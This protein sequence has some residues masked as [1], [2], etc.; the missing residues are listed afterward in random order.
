MIW[1]LG[2]TYKPILVLEGGGEYFYGVEKISCFVL[3]TLIIFAFFGN[4]LVWVA[5]LTVKRLQ[6]VTNFYIVSLATADLLVASFAMTTWLL[7]M[8]FG[9]KIL[10]NGSTIKSIYTL[11]DIACGTA[12]ILN[13]T[14]LGTIL[15]SWLY[16][17]L[18]AATKLFVPSKAYA[19]FVAL[20]SF[21]IPTSLMV[22]TYSCIFSVARRHVRVINVISGNRPQRRFSYVTE[23]KAAKVIGV[24]V[25]AF[26]V[27]WA[28]FLLTNLVINYCISCARSFPV[29]AVYVLKLLQYTSSALNPYI[30]TCLN[31]DFRVAVKRLVCRKCLRVSHTSLSRRS[32]VQ[33]LDMRTSN[34]KTVGVAD[35]IVA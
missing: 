9:G 22:F 3:I 21:F 6:R 5:F 28:P 29:E 26:L 24:V 10:T 13:L 33:M 4:T 19:L 7:H 30:Y 2:Q 17:I 23:M 14:V 11:V 8:S 18:V 12:S 31:A 27:C 35:S 20:T 1:T 16:A 32:R 25:G 15:F 34:L